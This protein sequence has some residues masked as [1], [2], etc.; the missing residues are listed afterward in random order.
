[1]LAGTYGDA[2]SAYGVAVVGSR[3][4]IA[5][6]TDLRVVDVSNP[7]APYEV[8]RVVLPEGAFDVTVEGERIVT[9][10]YWSGLYWLKARLVLYLPL[11]T[12]ARTG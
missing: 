9:A 1:V 5:N 2:D 6:W 8:E 11:V 7:A 3:A 12:M 10:G 4:Y